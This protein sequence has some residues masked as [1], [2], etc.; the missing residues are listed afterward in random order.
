MRVGSRLAALRV[1]RPPRPGR[2]RSPPNSGRLQPASIVHPHVLR[3]RD[4]PNYISA[5]IPPD[6]L[7]LMDLRGRPLNSCR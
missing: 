6:I 5:D 7:E 3:D 1:V 2:R 4:I